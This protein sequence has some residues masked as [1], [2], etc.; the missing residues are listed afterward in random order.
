L[1]QIRESL[2]EQAT[3]LESLQN[4]VV[5]QMEGQ[6]HSLDKKAKVL[7]EN[8]KFHQSPLNESIRL[9]LIEVAKAQDYLNTTASKEIKNVCATGLD[10]FEVIA[11]DVSSWVTGP[12]SGRPLMLEMVHFQNVA[13][14]P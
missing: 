4:G 11:G 14:W 9:I 7:E 6:V 1:E 12:T 10:A 5:R 13:L 8:L 2:N 3:I